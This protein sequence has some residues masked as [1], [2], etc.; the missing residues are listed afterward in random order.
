MKPSRPIIFAITVIAMATTLLAGGCATK[1]ARPVEPFESKVIEVA[2]NAWYE[3]C[4]PLQAGDKL[5]FSYVTDPPMA[6]S[7]RRHIG[8]ADVSYLM[9]DL[10]REDGG[11]FFVPESHDYCLRWTPPSLDATWPTLL[12]YIVRLN[13]NKSP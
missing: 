12:R 5:I 8:D 13:N 1:L 9:R 11:I 2:P 4:L 7:I 10:T 6:F 3:S